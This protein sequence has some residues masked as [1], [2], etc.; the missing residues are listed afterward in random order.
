MDS[1]SGVGTPPRLVAGQTIEL[2]VVGTA[3]G[4]PA[5]ATAVALNV[6]GILPRANGFVTAFPCGEQP[7]TSSLNPTVGHVIPN[8]VLAPVSP[9]GTVCFFTSTDVDL[10]VDEVGY[11]SPRQPLRSSH[12]A[13]R[14]ASPT[15]AIRSDLRS[16]PVKPACDSR[17][18]RPSPSP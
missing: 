6:T 8:L 16:T 12:Q 18:V 4:I 3:L 7:S 13:L 17:P 15:L 10:V 9:R 5:A 14:S 11:V 1:R 2:P